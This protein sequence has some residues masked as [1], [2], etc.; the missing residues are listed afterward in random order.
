MVN[1]APNAILLYSIVGAALLIYVPFLPVA[2]ARFQVG[3][4]MGAPR[5]MF[6]KL[7]GYA[8]RA[9]WAHQNAIEAFPIFAAAALMAYVTGANSPLIPGIALTFLGA[10]LLHGVFYISDFPWGRSLMFAIGSLCSFTLFG[11]S[12]ITISSAV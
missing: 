2:Y 9:T 11:L 6:D 4:N 12:L 10:R 3:Y 5:S 7:P 1:P 8:Q